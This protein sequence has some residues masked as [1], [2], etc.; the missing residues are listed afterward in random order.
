MTTVGKIMKKVQDGVPL[1]K[2]E[3][4]VKMAA[5]ITKYKPL[6]SQEAFFNDAIL[7]SLNKSEMLEL[8]KDDIDILKSARWEK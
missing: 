3:R 7:M 1:T 4:L 5:D 6:E 2:G 8:T